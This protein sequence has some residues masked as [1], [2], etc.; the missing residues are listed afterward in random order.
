MQGIQE[1]IPVSC[2]GLWRGISWGQNIGKQRRKR[3]KMTNE[4]LRY[5]N[6]FLG[7]QGDR[8]AAVVPT[9]C[10]RHLIRSSTWTSTQLLSFYF[11]VVK[12]LQFSQRDIRTWKMVGCKRTENHYKKNSQ[13]DQMRKSRENGGQQMNQAQEISLLYLS[14]VMLSL[15]EFPTKRSYCKM[16]FD[17]HHHHHHHHL[18]RNI[19]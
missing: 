3:Q 10:F 12:G 14:K 16:W 7:L 6:P 5:S 4:C 2:E 1:R 15:Q 13:E 8:R 11:L 19:D 9:I 17:H 18:I